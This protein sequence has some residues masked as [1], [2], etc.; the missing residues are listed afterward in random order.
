MAN[1][2]ELEKL[3]KS[4]EKAK[5]KKEKMPLLLDICKHYQNI[6]DFEQLKHYLIELKKLSEDNEFYKMSVLIMEGN[7]LL[8]KGDYNGALI[9]YF[10][11]EKMAKQQSDY[12]N[13]FAI[14]SNIAVI[15]IHLK[16]ERKSIDYYIKL[17][18]LITQH[19]EEE[20][21]LSVYNNIGA[22]YNNLSEYGKALDFLNRAIEI[23]KKYH[24]KE[25]SRVLFHNIA[26][27]YLSLKNPDMAMEYY[28]RS[29]NLSEETN[30]NKGIVLN[31]IKISKIYH[32]KKQEK[33]A[34]E[35]ENKAIELAQKTHNNSLLK[36]LYK[37]LSDQYEFFGN[38][39]LAMNYY[40]KYKSLD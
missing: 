17:A 24:N 16:E 22:S 7:L 8:E 1:N 11:A 13:L 9:N 4:L 23:S 3:I 38:Y 25:I 37:S 5:T 12:K 10:Q 32:I 31:L 14:Y 30:D 15:Y 36:E 26:D 28:L 27:T 19:G 6:N 20:E 2:T 21:L 40:K 33:Q 39:K 29:L 35:F 18:K 34:E